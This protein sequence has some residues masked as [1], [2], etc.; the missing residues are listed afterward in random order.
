VSLVPTISRIES[1]KH[2]PS[3]TTL[4]SLAEALGVTPCRLLQDPGK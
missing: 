1:G 3:L 2:L 4:L